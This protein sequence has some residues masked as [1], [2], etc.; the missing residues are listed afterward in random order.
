MSPDRPKARGT[1]WS[2]V[3]GFLR[4]FRT[5]IAALVLLTA[6]MSVV[7]MLPP[8]FTR[9]II[10]DVIG[11]G[12]RSRFLGLAI[13]TVGTPILLAAISYVQVVGIA[14]LGQRFVLDLRT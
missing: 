6:L 10:N 3:S 2:R 8:L 9:S 13:L 12:D 4:P 11:R 1:S 7:A 5:G 14:V